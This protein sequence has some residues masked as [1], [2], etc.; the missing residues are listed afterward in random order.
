VN[1]SI[2]K[3]GNRIYRRAYKAYL[4]L[5]SAYKAISDREERRILRSF[6]RLGMTAVDV[7]ANIGAHT[8][9]LARLCGPD[10]R[11]VAFEPSPENLQRLK[12]NVRDLPNVAIKA[13]AVGDRSGSIS[14]YLS[15]EMNIDHRTYDTGERRDRIEVPVVRLDD[16]FPSGSQV[17][18]L[19][20]DVQ[21]FER[22]VIEGARRLL[23]ENPHLKA[24]VE[25]W[26]YGLAQG[27]RDPAALLALFADLGLAYEVIGT[28][29]DPAHVVAR[30]DLT[31]P[32]HYCNLLVTRRHDR[33]TNA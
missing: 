6:L 28:A 27:G 7:G 21:G 26:P 5:Y 23:S 25:Y 31:R 17:D 33:W 32:D 1:P 2:L 29:K 10:G 11:V 14:L 18:L 15:R 12:A 20:V 8:R 9:Y 3:L 30:L 13:A 4:P 22:E 24:V 19:K 16:V